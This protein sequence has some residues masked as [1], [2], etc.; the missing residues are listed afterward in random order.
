MKYAKTS[1]QVGFEFFNVSMVAALVAVVAY[2]YVENKC[3]S[4]IALCL[5]GRLFWLICLVCAV[6]FFARAITLMAFV[7]GEWRIDITEDT[8]TWIAPGS[9]S[10]QFDDSFS[11]KINDIDQIIFDDGEGKKVDDIY[12][13]VLVFLTKS[14]TTYKVSNESGISLKRVV[15]KLRRIGLNIVEAKADI[16]T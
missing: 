1:R 13:P 5:F 3:W 12:C 9:P 6:G 16:L 2:F 10:L 15:K 7:K 14:G 11:V 8:I 4:E